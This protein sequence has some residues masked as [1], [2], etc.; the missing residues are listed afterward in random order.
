[1]SS[2]FQGCHQTRKN[3]MATG[4]H[5]ASSGPVRHANSRARPSSLRMRLSGEGLTGQQVIL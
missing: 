1:M 2:A 5:Q 4:L 3:P